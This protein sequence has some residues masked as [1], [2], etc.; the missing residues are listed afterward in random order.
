MS[1]ICKCPAIH[2]ADYA[3]SLLSEPVLVNA[4]A[5]SLTEAY[6]LYRQ[7]RGPVSWLENTRQ[8]KKLAALLYYAARYNSRDRCALALQVLNQALEKGA[9]HVLAKVSPEAGELMARA[10]RVGMELH[11]LYGFIRFTPSD[12]NTM[13]G[14]AELT[15]DTADLVLSYFAGRYRGQRIV[16]LANGRAH[17]W[18]NG[19]ITVTDAGKSSAGPEADGFAA[20]W[21]AYY[22]SQVI[23]GRL[24]RKLAVKHLPK[25]YWS[26]VP[27]GNKLK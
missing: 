14:R 23:E 9:E 2:R 27:E 20:F 13:T 3:G 15:H 1:R 18:D 6:R 8:G 16:L 25:K 7:S 4:D 12:D 21:D 22:D 11:R 19:K 26:W 5:F 24:N 10:R 17:I